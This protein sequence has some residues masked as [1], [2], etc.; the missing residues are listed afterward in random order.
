MTDKKT[1]RID[2]KALREKL[3]NYTVSFNADSFSFLE[4]EIAQVKTNNPIEL[5]DT[6]KLVQFIGIPVAVALLGCAVY[7]G[8]NYV[9][10]LPPSTPKKDTV[11]VVKPAEPKVEVKKEVP[12]PVITPS[13]V[14]NTEEKKKDTIIATPPQVVSQ[15]VKVK[16][17]KSTTQQV[18]SVKK[19]SGQ[20]NTVAKTKLD[21][22]R[23]NKPDTTSVT[24][25]DAV[26]KK[27]KKKRKNSLDATEDIR[28]SQPS[29]SEDEVIIPDNTPKQE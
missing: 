16:E 24:N 29:S 17:R 26:Q 20:V 3:T 7:F 13:V 28:Q 21:T 5:P 1:Y 6:K 14:V 8:V 2:E 23:K 4:N 19:D 10:N 11:T 18:S 25:K 27:K 15:P 22:V 12:P 9:K